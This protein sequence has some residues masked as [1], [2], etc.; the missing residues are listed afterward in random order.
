MLAVVIGLLAVT[1]LTDM[2]G[3]AL[4][5]AVAGYVLVLAEVTF[6]ASVAVAMR[7]LP[8]SRRVSALA[9]VAIGAA[10]LYCRALVGYAHLWKAPAAGAWYAAVMVAA[11]WTIAHLAN[12]LW[13]KDKLMACARG[14]A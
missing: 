3:E 8:R 6:A 9:A 14:S 5:T 11:A 12:R 10:W 1:L 2:P 7:A 4:I 13:T